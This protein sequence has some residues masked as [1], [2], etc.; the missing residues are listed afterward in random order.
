MKDSTDKRSLTATSAK[1]SR[2]PQISAVAYSTSTTNCSVQK[3]QQFCITMGLNWSI[4]DTD[5]YCRLCAGRRV[6][7]CTLCSSVAHSTGMCP[8]ASSLKTPSAGLNKRN[9]DGV[10][11]AVGRQRKFHAGVE[12][13]NNYNSSNGCNRRI[14]K[15]LHLCS[16]CKSEQ[17]C[18]AECLQRQ[19]QT[20]KG[21]TNTSATAK[22]NSATVPELNSRVRKK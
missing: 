22:D 9:A 17:H 12:I 13:C 7:A 1:L 11:D 6:N 16:W 5:L 20:G 14:C 2:W 19:R 4:R 8:L 18:G 3:L 15:F 21:T 10:N